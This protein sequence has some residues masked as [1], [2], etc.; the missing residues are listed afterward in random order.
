MTFKEVKD[1]CLEQNFY[2]AIAVGMESEFS[3]CSIIYKWDSKIKTL[4]FYIGKIR[5]SLTYG[6]LHHRGYLYVNY[7]RTQILDDFAIQIPSLC[8]LIAEKNDILDFGITFNK[9][10]FDSSGK[11]ILQEGDFGLTCATFILS[12]FE[13]A[14]IPLIDYENWKHRDE[15]A[16]WHKH[17]LEFFTDNKFSDELINHCKTN[18][19]CFRY[20]P[21]E[22]AV[23]STDNQL[24]SSYDFCIEK[25]ENLIYAI[26]NGIE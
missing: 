1:V 5:N 12:I 17:V 19:G 15:D 8:E 24:P 4:D 10:K 14:G 6:D 20:R 16:K 23:S 26:K 7:N 13:S 18:G 11:L 22:V 21:E 25:G 2:F 3:H 9:S